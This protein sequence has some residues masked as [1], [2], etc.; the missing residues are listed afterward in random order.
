[1]AITQISRIQIRRG[2][3]QDLPTLSSGEFGWSTDTNELWIGNGTASEGA[4][5][6]GGRTQIMTT[7]GSANIAALQS[8]VSTLQTQVASL[9]G[10]LLT[11]VSATLS[12]ASSGQLAV[13]TSN[14][15]TV[16]YTLSQGSVQRSGV[17]HLSR[18]A[19]GSTVGIDEDYTQTAA[20][21][22]VFSANANT[23]QAN[24]YYTTTTATSMLY[25]VAYIR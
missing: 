17:I 25:Q 2:L 15:A 19:S 1:M 18:F 4:P 10:Q 5:I 6:P 8:N 14:N 20:T 9:S 13:I 11:T 24:V 7:G 3:S 21:D 16:S 23:T 22:I 12:A